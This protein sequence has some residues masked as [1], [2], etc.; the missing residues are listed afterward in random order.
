MA[1]HTCSDCFEPVMGAVEV[2]LCPLH[3]AA[4][5]LLTACKS[6]G[7]GEINVLIFAAKICVGYPRLVGELRAK[8]E[9]EIAA[10]K[11]AERRE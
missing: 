7:E 10:I 4:D 3:A 6:G 9:L 1:E 2:T 8:R 5:E 11:A